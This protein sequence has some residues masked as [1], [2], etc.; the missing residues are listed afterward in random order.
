MSL[1][2]SLILLFSHES[3]SASVLVQYTVNSLIMKIFRGELR[4]FHYEEFL[5]KEEWE[6]FHYDPLSENQISH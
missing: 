1:Y 6:L 3:L 4:I 5:I 2:V